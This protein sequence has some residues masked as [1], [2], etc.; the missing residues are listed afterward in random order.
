MKEITS[1]LR[2]I[3]EKCLNDCCA[4]LANEVKDCLCPSCALYAFRFGKNPYRKPRSE[5]QKE[6]SRQRALERGF[7]KK[8]MNL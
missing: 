4:G 3:R 2:A 7:G 5:E 6:V 8:K 1:P